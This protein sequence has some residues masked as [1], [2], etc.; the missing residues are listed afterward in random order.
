MC[1]AGAVGLVLGL[2]LASPA[3]RRLPEDLCGG[4]TSLRYA[5]SHQSLVPAIQESRGARGH[6]DFWLHCVK[7]IQK[8]G[9]EKRREGGGEEND[10]MEK[11][12]ENEYW[13]G[14]HVYE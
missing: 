12:L 5:S 7:R 6:V 4:A 3:Q 11:G 10:N 14:V 9:S 13:S 8:K 1:G 2:R